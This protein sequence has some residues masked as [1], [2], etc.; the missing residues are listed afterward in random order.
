MR[1]MPGFVH[2][3]DLAA[4]AWKAPDELKSGICQ[5]TVMFRSAY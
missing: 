4:V 1:V 5:L 3:G 2:H